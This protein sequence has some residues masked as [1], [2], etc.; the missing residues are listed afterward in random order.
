MLETESFDP[1]DAD[2]D[3]DVDFK[4]AAI[5]AEIDVGHTEDTPK[6][7]W[8]HVLRRL[9]RMTLG[10]VLCLA[11]VAMMVLPGPGVVVIA[12]GLVVLS[13]D[14]AWA[15]RALRYLRKKAPGLEEEGPIPMSTI[16]VSL[17]LMVAAGLLTLWWFNGGN[18]TVSGWF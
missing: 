6:Q 2:R 1:A 7:A 13:R 10:T 15:D 18:D 11:G 12:A 14:V 3:G 5:R 4:D 9:G 8:H 16:I 17:M